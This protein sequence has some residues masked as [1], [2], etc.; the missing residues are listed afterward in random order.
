MDLQ[1]LESFVR[2]AELGSLTRAALVAGVSQPTL[3]RHIR[4]LELELKSHLLVRTGRGVEL[5][6]SGKCL[7][8]YGNAILKL[9]RQARADIQA[10]REQPT[11]RLTVGLP[12]R[13]AHVLTPE[14]VKQFRKRYPEASISVS[15]GLSVALREDLILGKIEI[16]L[17]FDPPPSPRL[18]Y[19]SL[20]RED[21]VLCGRPKPA[22]PLPARLAARELERYP[23]L[24]PSIPNAVRNVI[25]AGCRPHG[26]K[27][28]VVAEVDAVHTLLKLALSGQGYAIVP[29]SAAPIASI[30]EGGPFRISTIGSPRMRNNL[31]L[32]TARERPLSQLAQG[33]VEL[34]AAQDIGRLLDAGR[35]MDG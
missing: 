34:L 5:T 35:R 18:E 3:S 14:L 28:N 7:L 21:M 15:E 12:P 22:F 8:S 20:Y 32:A 6:E 31:V 16:A 2:V 25:E 4:L 17:L 30:V 33:T 29:R 23:V 27:L 10:L 24:V 1:Q 9:T 13:I 26:I 11:G 19:R